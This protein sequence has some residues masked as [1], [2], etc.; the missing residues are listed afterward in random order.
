MLKKYLTFDAQVSRTIFDFFK[1]F[2]Y[3]IY[4]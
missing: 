1:Y 4:I 3:I 2:V